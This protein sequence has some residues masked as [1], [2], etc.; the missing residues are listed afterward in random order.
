MPLKLTQKDWNRLFRSQKLPNP[1]GPTRAESMAGCRSGG[2]TVCMRNNETLSA[3]E[4]VASF[5]PLALRKI[6]PISS[7]E[8]ACSGVSP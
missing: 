8:Q 1:D 2:R 7:V 5:R 3:S 4:K 6:P